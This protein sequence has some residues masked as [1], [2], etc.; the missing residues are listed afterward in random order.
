[1]SN[2]K[3]NS[4]LTP[5]RNGAWAAADA[6]EGKRMV[7]SWVFFACARRPAEANSRTTAPSKAFFIAAPPMSIAIL[8]PVGGLTWGL[9]AGG[10]GLGLGAGGWGTG[11]LRDWG[12]G[13]CGPG[14]DGRSSLASRSG[15]AGFE[16]YSLHS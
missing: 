13:R 9:G 11:G 10:W 1:M 14:C 7:P 5:T 16:Y 6:D 2:S 15:T 4:A 8:A 12:T 3:L